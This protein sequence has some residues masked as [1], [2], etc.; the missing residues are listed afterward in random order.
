MTSSSFSPDPFVP[1]G[2]QDL[3]PEDLARR[4][5]WRARRGLL[6]NDLL[7]QAFFEQR[8][9]FITQAEHDGLAR[10]LNLTDGDLMDLILARR[11][12]DGDLDV[13]EVRQVLVS[14]RSVRLK[15]E[16]REGRGP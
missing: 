16:G 15:P 14:L 4:L 11:E 5:R 6:E 8:Q 7:I 2:R 3:A 10:L 12:P 1:L 9:G 13:A